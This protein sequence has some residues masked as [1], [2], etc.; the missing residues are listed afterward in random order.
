M[1]KF[2]IIVNLQPAMKPLVI[3]Y[4]LVI[5]VMLQFSWWA[6]LLV[7]LNQEVYEHKME[8]VELKHTY[9]TEKNEQ[10]NSLLKKLHERWLMVAGEG[11]VFLA[12]L[13]FGINMTRKAFRKEFLVAKQ[14][15]N[16]LLSVTHEFKSPLAGIKLSLQTLQKYDLDKEKKEALLK[17]SL[18]ETERIHNLIENALMAAQIE[19]H[20]IELQKEEFNLSELL[21]NTIH[22]KAEQYRLTHE[23]T[24]DIPQTVFMNGDAL[25]ISSMMLNLIENAEKYSPAN[26]KTHVE[27]INRDKYIVIRVSDNGIGIPDEEKENIFEMFYRV[28]NEEVRKTKGTGLGLYIVKNVAALHNGKVFIK[29]NKPNGTVFE[30][31]FQK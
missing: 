18:N 25:A 16:F 30:I 11:T 22:D 9:N 3:F 1:R 7:Q 17:R 31:I 13:V 24:A 21:Q 28:G 23:I 15:K 2:A 19:G 6:F 14:Q 29:D 4:A 12:L 8:M 27:L 10:H 20:S 5:Y 26:S